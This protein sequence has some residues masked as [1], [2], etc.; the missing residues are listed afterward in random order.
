LWGYLPPEDFADH[1]VHVCKLYNDALF[2][3]EVNYLGSTVLKRTM[4]NWTYGNVAREEKWD[5]VALKP[6]KYGFMTSEHNKPILVSNMVA[7]LKSRHYRIA[8]REL[9]AEL[10]T[11][12]FEGY[13]SQGNPMHSAGGRKHDDRV[14]AMALALLAV[15]QSP[16]LYTTMT[17]HQHALPTAAQ[18][19]ISHAGAVPVS[20]KLPAGFPDDLKNILEGQNKAA[21]FGGWNPITPRGF[22]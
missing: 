6:H 8:S 13:T 19:G 11:F 5:E 7:M 4:Q 1:A 2:M 22:F 14:I 18:L 12:Q 21:G 3:P 20:A 9:N 10:S 16:G 17:Q 15:R